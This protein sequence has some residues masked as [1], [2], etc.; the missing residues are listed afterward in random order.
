M[1]KSGIRSLLHLDRIVVHSNLDMA[2]MINT[3]H[4]EQMQDYSPL[5]CLPPFSDD[6][7]V[8]IVSP[9]RVCKVLLELNPRKACGPRGT[10]NLL[11]L[12][13]ADF[14]TST[15]CHILN[16]SFAWQKL[17]RS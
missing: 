14:L 7:E 8:L 12:E 16:S 10:N 3:V 5:A 17:P 9:S 4:L 2:N 11:L 13:Y 15:V 1:V 6:S